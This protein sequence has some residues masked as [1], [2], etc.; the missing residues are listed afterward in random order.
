MFLQNKLSEKYNYKKLPSNLSEF[1]RNEYLKSLPD[2]LKLNGDL[3]F[4][5]YSKKETLISIGY[6]RIVIGDYG[7]FIEFDKN[8]VVYE[9]IQIKKGEEYRIYDDH[10]NKNVKYIWY[11]AK[12]DSNIKIYYQQKTVSYADY[13]PNVFYVSPYEIKI[14]EF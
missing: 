6:N 13:I 14:L 9:N 2:L 1:V 12:D 5:I 8:Q 4:E 3:D 11:T 7:A 10:Y